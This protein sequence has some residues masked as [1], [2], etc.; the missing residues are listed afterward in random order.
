MKA[1]NTVTQDNMASKSKE[2]DDVVIW[3]QEA[4]TLR[5]QAEAKLVDADK[6]LMAAEG[7]TK[8]CCW[9]PLSRPSPSVKTPPS[10]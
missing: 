4:N 8:G 5:E 1:I 3:E 2:L 6:K 10:W 7:E 9:N